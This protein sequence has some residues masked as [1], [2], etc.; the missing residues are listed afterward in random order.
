[1][2]DAARVK[3]LKTARDHAYAPY[4]GF[5]V[6][7]LAE[8]GQ[9]QWYAG[10]NVETAHYK[11][12]CAEAVAIAAMISAGYRQL[13]ELYIM[14]P[15]PEPCP[16]CGDCRQRIYEFA[17]ADTRI[18]LLDAGGETLKRYT[19]EELLPHAFGPEFS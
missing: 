6:S 1:M 18:H 16:P 14:G 9:G 10:A 7:A 4:S 5:A 2:T 17:T 3:A 11:S 19:I 12:L 15:G 8:N 13:D